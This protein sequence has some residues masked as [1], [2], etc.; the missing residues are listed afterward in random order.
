MILKKKTQNQPTKKWTEMG[1]N[2]DPF[3]IF[4]QKN[5]IFATKK[6]FLLKIFTIF[7]NSFDSFS[8]ILRFFGVFKFSGQ[9]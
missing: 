8:D 3:K 1:K 5:L 6:R 9:F 7:L 2:E 4:Y